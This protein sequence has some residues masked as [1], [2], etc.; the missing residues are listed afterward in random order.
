MAMIPESEAL[1][2]LREGNLRY[3]NA[4]SS[5]DPAHTQARRAATVDGQ[6]PFAVILGC[7]DSRVPVELVF[8]QGPG[9]LFV[10]R[11]AGNVAARTQIG[12]IEY[13]AS[14]LGTRLVVVLGHSRCGAIA[15]TVNELQQPSAEP[16]P[17]LGFIVDRIRPAVA[18][19]LEQHEGGDAAELVE[20]AVRA[21]VRH[22]VDELRQGS[23]TIVSLVDR[24]DLRIVGACYSLET[25]LVEFLD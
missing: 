18:P 3:A 22:V 10:V 21:N 5:C 23:P 4:T 13:A 15:S 7:S 17:N 14:K 24:Q 9:D 19:V 6:Q 20:K 8:D 12:S 16:S 1:D 11:V 25:G 2:R